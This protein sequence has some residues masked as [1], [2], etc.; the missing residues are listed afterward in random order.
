MASVALG[1][2]GRTLD[3]VDFAAWLGRPQDRPSLRGAIARA[4]GDPSAQ[5]LYVVPGAAAPV[6]DRGVEV[7]LPER[8]PSRQYVTIDGPH[9]PSAHIVYDADLHLEPAGVAAVGQVLALAIDH[10]RLTVE[11]RAREAEVRASRSRLLEETA[12]TRRQV[13]Q[14]LHDGA[15]TRLLLAAMQLG[16]VVE[17]VDA[18]VEPRIRAVRGELDAAINE[19][20]RIANGLAP[21]LLMERGLFAAV[22]DLV[23]RMPLATSKEFVGDDGTLDWALTVGA[24]F[25]VNEAVANILKHADATA[26]TAR[27]VRTP[28]ALRIEVVDDGRGGVCLAAAGAGRGLSGMVDRAAALGGSLTCTSPTGK[29]TRIEVEL[30]CAS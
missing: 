8:S 7:S 20:R 12:R 13:A 18:E 10:E 25:I 21:P 30:P 19:I 6:D 17:E 2:F 3:L 1:T 22:D 23:D 27:I 9:G 11:V 14:D 26:A 5:L 24:Y 4:L 28:E 29:G 15:Q 16:Q